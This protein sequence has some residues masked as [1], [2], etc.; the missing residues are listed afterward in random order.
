MKRDATFGMMVMVGFGG[1]MIEDLKD[2]AWRQAPFN[3]IVAM[4]MLDELRMRAVFDGVRGSIPLDKNAIANL[5]SKVSQFADSASS[6]LVEL[7]LNP[8]L[9]GEEGPLAVDCVM[10]VD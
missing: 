6:Q 1:I 10:I 7:D 2:V 5:L 4:Q 9:M 3:E 8:I